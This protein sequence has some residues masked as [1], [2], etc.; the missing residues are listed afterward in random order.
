[1]CKSFQLCHQTTCQLC[2]SNKYEHPDAMRYKEDCSN[3]NFESEVGWRA[4]ALDV[5]HCVD[6][7]ITSSISLNHTRSFH[8]DLDET[9]WG[10]L[11]LISHQ[12]L[13]HL[14]PMFQRRYLCSGIPIIHQYPAIYLQMSTILPRWSMRDTADQI[15]ALT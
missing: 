5:R 13:P 14:K 3:F 2:S 4:Q 12:L 8:T 11:H 6:D 1:L 15:R 7:I 10:N 9:M